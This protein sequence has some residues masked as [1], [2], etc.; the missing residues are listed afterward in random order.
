MTR[1]LTAALVAVT[2]LV[3]LPAFADGYEDQAA[4]A[5]RNYGPLVHQSPVTTKPA[6]LPQPKAPAFSTNSSWMDHASQ[7]IDGGGN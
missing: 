6:A 7:N 2:A 4:D 3:S 5:I 1:T